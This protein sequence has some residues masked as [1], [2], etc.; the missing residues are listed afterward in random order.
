MRSSRNNVPRF[1]PH[2][3]RPIVDTLQFHLERPQTQ[4]MLSNLDQPQGQSIH[5]SHNARAS[6]S[7]HNNSHH[8]TVYDQIPP[9]P[10]KT[11]ASLHQPLPANT[12]FMPQMDNTST[13]SKTIFRSED[14]QK[15]AS[16]QLNYDNLPAEVKKEQDK[17]AQD[18]IQ[19]TGACIGGFKWSREGKGYRCG[20]GRCYMTDQLISEGKGGFLWVSQPIYMRLPAEKC[21]W[22]GPH[23]SLACGPGLRSRG[24]RR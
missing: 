10:V 19:Y 2:H 14:D 5:S 11:C 9:S 23:Y 13:P 12:H 3:R 4:L 18:Y 20:S 7:R 1:I 8:E 6:A 16:Q 17:W 21:L 15:N 24:H 22:T